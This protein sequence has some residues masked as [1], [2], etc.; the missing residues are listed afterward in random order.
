MMMM[1]IIKRGEARAQR[2]ALSPKLFSPH[3]QFFEP[4]VPAAISRSALNT[5]RPALLGDPGFSG[6]GRDP[7]GKSQ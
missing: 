3:W 2:G 5:Q 1:I 4:Q 6:Q 7:D